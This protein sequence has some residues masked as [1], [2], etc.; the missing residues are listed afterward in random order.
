M[1]PNQSIDL[2][3]EGLGGGEYNGRIDKA[4][5]DGASQTEALVARDGSDADG[6]NFRYTS[7]N[8]TTDKEPGS[9]TKPKA[10]EYRRLAFSQ[11]GAEGGSDSYMVVPY[12]GEELAI[13]V[14]KVTEQGGMTQVELRAYWTSDGE[15]L[16]SEYDPVWSVPI[17]VG[18]IEGKPDGTA[19][20]TLPTEPV[21]GFSVVEVRVLEE[22]T[23]AV[24][25]GKSRPPVSEASSDLLAPS[26][27]D[28]D[29]VGVRIFP[30]PWFDIEEP[31]QG[32]E[33]DGAPSVEG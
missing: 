24:S 12:H 13:T 14:V 1:A 18:A 2:K 21:Q 31:A 16:G 28:P 6:Y 33:N 27:G 11:E 4:P 22:N 17:G 9:S 7:P 15:P 20:L 26:K 32:G 10:I 8:T 5:D 29:Y 30:A 3:V 23:Y 25:P 19:V